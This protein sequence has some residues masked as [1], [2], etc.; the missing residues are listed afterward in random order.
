MTTVATMIIGNIT[1]WWSVWLVAR[2]CANWGGEVLV[3]MFR[4]SNLEKST[5]PSGLIPHS[6]D[7][8]DIRFLVC[9]CLECFFYSY[10]FL[11]PVKQEVLSYVRL[12]L[13]TT[14]MTSV[15][16]LDQAG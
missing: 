11:L 14:I 2:V 15:S 8:E 5:S 13:V 12:N 10:Y 4:R 7:V 16:D 9:E 1:C 6:P 3:E